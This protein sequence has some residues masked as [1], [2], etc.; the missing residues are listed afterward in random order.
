MD[1]LV[2]HYTAQSSD[3]GYMELCQA[4]DRGIESVDAPPPL[5]RLFEEL[6][7]VPF[8]V[9]WDRLR[10]ASRKIVR[11]GLLTSLSFA[12]YALPHVYLAT[13]NKPLGIN[14]HLF[15][16]VAQRYAR[17]SRFVT[18]VFLP[19]GLRRHADGF[20]LAVLVRYAHAQMRYALLTRGDW[21]PEHYETPINQ[22]HVAVCAVFFSLFVVHGLQRLGVRFSAQEMESVILTWRYVSYLLGVDSEL[23]VTSEQDAE[24]LVA[25]SRSLELD[26]DD[27]SR[28]LLRSTI[29]SGPRFLGIEQQRVAKPLIHFVWQLARRMLGDT[30]ADAFDVPCQT[31]PYRLGVRA[32]PVAVACLDRA[33]WLFPRA[34]RNFV[35]VE[36]WLMRS[37]YDEFV[38]PD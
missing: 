2:A 26:A 24:R 9:D 8:W 17:T 13:A 25:I 16:E 6:D 5:T 33:P 10:I 27:L 19:D 15:D 21:G 30:L 28:R 14:R 29:E 12:T 23:I 7:H 20:R 34:V 22:V 18:D 1:S 31:L 35:G 36:F 38:K 4:I 37:D 3:R 32:L 11:N